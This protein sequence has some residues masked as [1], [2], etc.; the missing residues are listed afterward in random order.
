MEVTTEYL[1]IFL[2]VVKVTDEPEP[3]ELVINGYHVYTHPP[4]GLEDAV[5]DFLR[6]YGDV[7]LIAAKL[8]SMK[9]E[10][11]RSIGF[12]TVWEIEYTY[13]PSSWLGEEEH[14]YSVDLLGI[15]DE[16]KWTP[17]SLGLIGA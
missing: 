17:Q 4:E 14:D 3:G 16:T 10:N 1:P 15:A 12:W 9:R 7:S 2:S 8:E 6:G 5:F 11:S 13:T